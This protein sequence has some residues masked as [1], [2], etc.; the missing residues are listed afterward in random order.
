M[1]IVGNKIGKLGMQELDKVLTFNK[2]INGK[3]M[4]IFEE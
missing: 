4:R 1:N 3:N 2:N